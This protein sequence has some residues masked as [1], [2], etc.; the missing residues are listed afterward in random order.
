M[1]ITTAERNQIVELTV[2]MFN[3]APGETY[4]AQIVALYESNG[5]SLQNLANQLAGTSIFQ[6]MHPNFETAEEFAAEF[7]TPLGLQ[8]DATAKDFVIA[9]VNAG[10]PK[11]QIMY[12]GYVALNAVPADGAAQYVAANA[13]LNNK[14]TVAEYYSTNGGVATTLVDLQTVIGTVTAS[15]ASVTAAIAAISAVS[16]QE[17]SLTTG[18]D[19]LVG[20]TGNDTFSATFDAVTAATADTLTSFDTINGG[21]GTDTLVIDGLGAAIAAG[22]IA[23]LGVSLTSVENLTVQNTAAIT[24][25]AADLGSSVQKLALIGTTAAQGVTLNAAITEVSAKTTGAVTITGNAGADVLTTVTLENVAAASTSASDKLATV[26]LKNVSSTLTNTAAAGTRALTVN[27]ENVSG[28]AA[29]LDATA[30]TVTVNASGTTANALALTVGAATEVNINATNSKGTTVTATDFTAAKTLNSTGTGDLTIDV[31]G[32]AALT[33]VNAATASGKNDVTIAATAVTV[34]T[35]SGADKVTQAAALG[36]TQKISTGAGDDSVVLGG[37]LTAGAVVDGGEGTDNLSLT[38]ATATG[39]T[40]NVQELVFSNF[41]QVTI[42]DALAGTLAMA[43]LDDIQKVVLAG[44]AGT[45]TITG[46]T[47]GATVTYKSANTGT[48]T[49]TM[50]GAVAGAADVLNLVVNTDGTAAVGTVVAA[51]VETVN[52]STVDSGTASANVAAAVDT[53]TLQATAATSIVVTG[54]NGLN[55]TNVGNVKVTSFDASGVAGDNTAD[56]AA[57]LAVTFASANT[58]ATAAVTI[59]GGAGDDSLTGNAGLDTIT[60]G[61]GKDTIDG[62]AGNDNLSGEAGDDTITGGT[63][64]DFIDGGAGKD[65]INTGLGAD[66]ITTGDGTDTVAI[67]LATAVTALSTVTDFNAGTSTTAVDKLSVADA[68]AGW[69]AAATV[70]QSTAAGVVDAQLVILD[71]GTF[72]S[73]ADAAAAADNIQH[74]AAVTNYLFVWL[75][76]SNVVHIS[77]GLQDAAAEVAVDQYVDLVKLTGVTLDTV[78]IGDFVFV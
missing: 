32:A 14:T 12:E 44:D 8:D 5:R 50:T 61:A 48:S 3:A 68:G 25:N 37:A 13:I 20:T 11:G 4:L 16:G 56:T 38:S 33:T 53:M 7:L 67:N 17:F 1:A 29:V 31:S 73:L 75:D 45:Q 70:K 24:L 19:N 51:D 22:N 55:L 57:G 18:S 42:S 58:T 39:A 74:N 2:L 64:N 30:T 15:A 77:Q 76:S 63:G 49:I 35:G 59:K 69:A 26:N 9:K 28:A 10:V 60:G 47:S 34:T 27:A 62:G 23:T 21:A 40:N 54:R 46:L 65:T 72:G 43:N 66:T 78:D 36:A 52:I 6:S 41:E 71:G